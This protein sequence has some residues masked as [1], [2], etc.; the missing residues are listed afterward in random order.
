MLLV[1][2]T[3]FES[4]DHSLRRTLDTASRDGLSRRWRFGVS[5]IAVVCRANGTRAL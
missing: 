4:P 2:G 1:R 5:S 3:G